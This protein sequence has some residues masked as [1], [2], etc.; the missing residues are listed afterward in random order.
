MTLGVSVPIPACVKVSGRLLKK[1]ELKVI[2]KHWKR[3]GGAKKY[4][5]ST[6]QFL[7]KGSKK[8]NIMYSVL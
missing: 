3:K 4:I 8:T 6:L 5:S 1:K 7:N 2:S